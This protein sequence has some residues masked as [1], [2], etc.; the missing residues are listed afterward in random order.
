MK[1]FRFVFGIVV[2][3]LFLA[4][5]DPIV[6]DNNFLHVSGHEMVDGAGNTVFLRGVGLGNWLLPE[7]YMWKFG[8]DGD[9]PRKIEKI[10]SDLIGK[11]K[12]DQFWKDFRE[13]YITEDDIKRIAEL[14]FNSVRPALNSRL[15]LTEGDTAHFIEESF[16]LIDSLVSWC[17]K[18]E[19]YVIIDIH[20]APGGQTG[21]NIDDSP[22]DEPELFMDLR[23]QDRLVELW[24]KIAKRYHNN[25]TVAAYNLLNEPLPKHTGAADKYGH[26]LEPLYKRITA[27]IREVD[28]NHMITLEGVDWAND[29]S[30]FG[31]PFDDNTFYQF[32]YYCWDRP[33]YLKD[34][35]KYLEYRKK[36]NTPVWVGETGEKG[37]TIYWATTQYFEAN[38]IGWSFWP[39][40]KMDTKNTAYSINKPLNWDQI[41]E[42]SHGR[43]KP[44][45][46]LATKAFDEL[47]ENIKLNNCVFF[48]DVVN[49]LFRRV[50]AKIEAENY[51]HDGYNKSYFVTDTSARA[52][53]YRV[54]EPVAIELFDFTENQFWSEQCIKLNSKEW[55]TYSFDNSELDKAKIIIRAKTNKDNS[56][57]KFTLN[58]KSISQNLKNKDW[59]EIVLNDL[60]LTRGRN[61]IRLFVDTGRISFDWINVLDN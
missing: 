32:H 22:N 2:F 35:S 46:N 55:V 56:A 26:L 50:P 18:H 54:N 49:S 9:R 34:I 30:I 1:C 36:L 10:V 58:D 59:Q 37:N 38:N 53:Y 3:S 40:K 60:K 43:G 11:E 21:A 29:W 15:F 44:S 51:G 13:Y 42:Y 8:P 33:D 5:C 61:K 17:T 39:W 16:V 48:P 4:S 7:G 24:V 47:I 31:K 52:K 23:N 57:F 14:G 25:P 45:E 6:E 20:G 28:K 12:A 19:L 41:I 27:A